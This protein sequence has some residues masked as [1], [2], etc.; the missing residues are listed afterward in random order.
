MAKSADPLSD[1]MGFDWDEG[2]ASKNWQ[3]HRVAA[4]EAD[5]LFFHEPLVVRGDT[6]H[7][8]REKRCYALG[9]TAAGR[10]LFAAFTIRRSLIR[11]ISVRDMNSRE[12][13]VY[14]NHQNKN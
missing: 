3:R 13:E 14:G 7:S 12:R 11:I 10:L 2:N 4:D 8:R 5:D 1:C 6:R 9:Q